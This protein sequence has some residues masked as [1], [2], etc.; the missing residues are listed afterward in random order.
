MSGALIGLIGVVV[1]AA[2]SGGVTWFM[3]RRTDARQTRA[4]AR[5]VQDELGEIYSYAHLHVYLAHAGSQ[6]P[7]TFAEFSLE[8]WDKQRGILAENLADDAWL[9]VAIAYRNVR[10]RQVYERKTGDTDPPEDVAPTDERVRELVLEAMM[11]LTSL[12]APWFAEH[13]LPMVRIGHEGPEE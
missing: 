10:L 9:K 4:A 2:L 6:S 11:A 8:A 5:L 7:T 1:G 12:G 13:Y 3:A